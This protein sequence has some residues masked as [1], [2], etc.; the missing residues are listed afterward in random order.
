[1]K[2][3]QIR[4]QICHAKVKE[5]SSI[6]DSV[7]NT[8][9]TILVLEGCNA[10]PQFPMIVLTFVKEVFCLVVTS[11]YKT[12]LQNRTNANSEAFKKVKM[13]KILHIYLKIGIL[14]A[15]RLK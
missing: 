9:Q 13:K 4:T 7:C 14:D 8:L 2:L 3:G 15:D 6:G 10:L 11:I 5:G 12:R 1:M